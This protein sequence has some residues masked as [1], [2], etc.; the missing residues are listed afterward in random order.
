MDE[1][2]EENASSDLPAS[3]ST[4]INVE[5]LVEIPVEEAAMDSLNET[6]QPIPEQEM[7]E[8]QNEAE[9]LEI[10]P[11]E[12]SA[13]EN[14]AT[15]AMSNVNSPSIGARIIGS[16]AGD[17]VSSGYATQ[18]AQM[19]I[20]AALPAAEAFVEGITTQNLR[21]HGTEFPEMLINHAIE[22]GARDAG[23]L[24]TELAD[25]EPVFDENSVELTGENLRE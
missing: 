20:D 17:P 15:A 22:D 19:G 4:D 21:G 13:F 7:A 9:A 5:P 8:L 1:G 24:G 2:L 14:I 3:D 23:S 11:Y 10:E 16:L 6:E 25:N 12:P 18:L